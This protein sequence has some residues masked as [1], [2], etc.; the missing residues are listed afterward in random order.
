[1]KRVWLI[2]LLCCV[3]VLFAQEQVEVPSFVLGTFNIRCPGDLGEN[4][5][6]NRLPRCRE[7]IAS[8]KLEIFGLQEA[9]LYQIEGL[10]EGTNY[11][12]IGGGRNDFKKSGE[13]S[14]IIYNPQRFEELQSG[15]FGLSENLQ[16]PGLRSWNSAC[17]RIC[18]WGFFLD[19]KSGKRFFYYNTHLD[20]KSEEARIKGIQLIVEHAKKTAEGVPMILSGDFNALPNSTTIDVVSGLLRDS[21]TISESKPTGAQ[22]T[23][24]AY[25]KIPLPVRIDYIFVSEGV[26]VLSYHVDKTKPQG[27][28]ASDHNPVIT[29]IIIP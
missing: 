27:G 26:R 28:F 9:F 25:G 16:E 22:G 19:K 21:R 15:L 5:W 2:F 20:H 24:H 12:F 18:T 29:N 8:N 4:T 6:E 7:L 17:P 13:Y 23:Y 10:L 3:G 1:M 14:C 11:R